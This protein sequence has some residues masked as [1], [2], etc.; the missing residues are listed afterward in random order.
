MAREKSVQLDRGETRRRRVKVDC[1]PTRVEVPM[2][3]DIPV[4]AIE[5]EIG[6]LRPQPVFPIY[7]ASIAGAD[8]EQVRA[9]RQ[10]LEKIETRMRPSKHFHQIRVGKGHPRLE[11]LEP[12]N[13]PTKISGHLKSSCEI[14]FAVGLRVSWPP[15][16]KLGRKMP[17]MLAVACLVC[18]YRVH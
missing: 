13:E 1:F 12:G 4:D 6:P 11:R 10:R 8:I 16:A 18:E 15:H 3:A 17:H 5:V 2:F 14:V 9:P 7:Q